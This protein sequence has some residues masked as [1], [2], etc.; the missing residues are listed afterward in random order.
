MTYPAH[1]SMRRTVVYTYSE[2][3]WPVGIMG[4]VIQEGLKSTAT[5]NVDW[6]FL[7]LIPTVVEEWMIV[8]CTLHVCNKQLAL[9]QEQTNNNKESELQMWENI[10]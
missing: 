7:G 10:W 8:N 1:S 6:Y 2:Q 9:R 3:V 4:V 5:T